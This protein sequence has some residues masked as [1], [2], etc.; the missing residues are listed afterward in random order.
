MVPYFVLKLGIIIYI[1][2]FKNLHK[3]EP[4][5]SSVLLQCL[6]YA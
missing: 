2:K 3:S 4:Q 5:N 6:P 1:Y